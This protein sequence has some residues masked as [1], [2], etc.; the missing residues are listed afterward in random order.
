MEETLTLVEKTAFMKGLPALASIPTEA[1]AELAGRAREVHLDQGD[2][3]F[4]EG[5]PYRGVF[6]VVEGRLEQRKGRALVRVVQSGE[7]IGE[8]W[9]GEGEPHQYGAVASTHT[10]VLSVTHEDMVDT[11]LDYPEFGAALVRALS[12]RTHE[13]T[14]RILELETLVARLHATL[15]AAGIEPPDPREPDAPPGA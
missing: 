6:L 12:L 7:G 3:L 14:G 9:L 5:D 15:R 2:V 1:L 11:M 8:L 13:L 4:R 10:H